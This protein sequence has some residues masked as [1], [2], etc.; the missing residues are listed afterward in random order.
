[1]TETP[2]AAESPA[3]RGKG[4]LVALGVAALLVVGAAVTGGVLWLNRGPDYPDHWDS[5]VDDLV[6][7][8]EKERGLDFE[9]PVYIDFLSE[10]DFEEQVTSEETDLTDEDKED[11]EHDGA[12]MRALGLLDHDVDLFD[13]VNDLYGGGVLGLYDPEDERIRV[14]GE[15]LTLAVKATLVHEL[16]HVLQDQHFDLEG[17]SKELEEIDD[18][19]QTAAWQALVEGDANR[20]QTSWTQDL[21]ADD[22]KQLAEDAAEEQKATLRKLKDV[23]P[24]L[25]TSLGSS[26]AFG[27]ALLALA[28]QIDGDDEVDDLFE[29]PP[30]TEEQ[31]LDPWTLLTDEEE[32]VEVDTPGLAKGEKDF[33]DDT[34]GS[35]SLL[36]VLAERIDP[37]QALAAADGW[38]GDH[39]VS[40]ERGRTTC[41]RIDYRGDTKR[42]VTEMRTALRQWIEDGPAGV[43]KVSDHDG[44]LLFESC[45]PGRDAVTGNGGS[46]AALELAVGRTALATEGL[47]QG[48]SEKQARCFA[49]GIIDEFT[50]KEFES[51]NTTGDPDQDMVTRI[52]AI[53]AACR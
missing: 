49:D 30:T 42:D 39:Y 53:A 16:T 32:P 50:T 5:R 9:H 52:Q 20:I 3:R 23:P 19:S 14:R 4:R 13:A 2:V 44:G 45:D 27:E 35:P 28:T 1:M 15:K 6:D 36:F 11:I 51:L 38:G 12:V 10:E 33:D 21:P 46:Q 31:L 40:F 26:Y 24:F 37:K 8:V 22:K 43:A 18:S 7:Y 48:A 17:K 25:R 41:I 34:F 47:S 29:H